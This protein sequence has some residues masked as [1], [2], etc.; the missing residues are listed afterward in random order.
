M[1]TRFIDNEQCY[2]G[3]QLRSLYAYLSYGL[4]GDS[5]VA[6]IG[7][8]S[9]TPDHMVDGEDLLAGAT[10]A[11]SQMLHFIIEKF[12]TPLFSAV[13]LQRLF[14]SICLEV[15]HA[16]SAARVRASA[17]HRDGDDIYLKVGQDIGKM[18]ISIATVSPVSALI[19]FAIN[20]SNQGTPV[21]TA[22]LED[23]QIDPKQF[24]TEVLKKFEA[25]VHSIEEA[26]VKV[27]WVR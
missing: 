2:D 5:T 3:S 27:K 13:V 23:L 20:C 22:A 18:S 6:W 10:I 16:E 1:K 12:A 4:Q 8:C 24:A 25:E 14:A 15:L 11:G 17:F 21:Q 9:V 26:T 7:P 19:H